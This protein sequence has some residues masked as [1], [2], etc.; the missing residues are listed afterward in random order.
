M[1]RVALYLTT[2][3]NLVVGLT[4]ILA[5]VAFSLVGQLVWDTDKLHPLS[6]PL[7]TPPSAGFPFGTDS[8]GRDLL[9]IMIVG[10]MLTVKV[11]LIAGIIGV[12]I[13][14]SIA[15]VSGYYGGTVDAVIKVIIDVLITIPGLMILIVVA[16][17]LRG[18]M[19]TDVMAIIIGALAWREPARQIRSQVLVMREAEYIKI[20]RLSGSGPWRIIFT[21][22]I[23]NLLPYLGAMFVAAVSGG[24]LAS[25][26]IESLGLGAR[27]EPTL[28]VTIYYMMSEGAFLRGLW[29]WIVEP[30]T[31][32]VI[33]F[34]GM[35]LTSIGLDEFANPR[36][37]SR[38]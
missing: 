9:S 15:F 16:S 28:G 20:A 12:A 3:P 36:L 34:I 18:L 33:L 6:G 23:P 1:R 11:G 29:W 24:V 37:R 30:I 25:V 32:L 38:T 13:G 7:A 21:E 35:Y 10:T 26:G 5:L 17:T 4:L 19:S 14:T 31:V 27:G 22:M 2:N 8:V